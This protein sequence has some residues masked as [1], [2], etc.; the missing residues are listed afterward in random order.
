MSVLCAFLRVPAPLGCKMYAFLRVPRP[1]RNAAGLLGLRYP[2]DLSQRLVVS[3]AGAR[4][5]A[6]HTNT[7]RVSNNQ[8][9]GL[10]KNG[11]WH[12]VQ[13]LASPPQ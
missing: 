3:A 9:R 5:P 13:A 10:V 7:E 1:P 2:E 4:F 6:T 8:A 11:L 12:L